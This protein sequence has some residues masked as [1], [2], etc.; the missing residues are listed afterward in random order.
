MRA[1]L[2][3]VV[4]SLVVAACDQ[5]KTSDAPAAP[6]LAAARA[7]SAWP[8]IGAADGATSPSALVANELIRSN[9]YVVF[10]ASGSMNESRCSGD[11]SKLAVAKDAL[12][13]FAKRLPANANL[14]LHV[15]DSQ[16]IRQVL[17]LGPLDR[18][19][20]ERSV[21][22]IRAGGGTPLA[23]SA[24]EAYAVLTAQARRQLGYG[25]YHLVIVTDGEATGA[26]PRGAVDRIVG[27]SP[28]LVNTIGFCIKDDHSLNQAGR[29]LY[30]AAD[31]PSALDQTL[32][33][34]LAEAPSFD[35]TRFEAAKK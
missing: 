5:N 19:A 35:V 33:D 13:R 11:R 4:V 22:A 30:K 14:G 3:G 32:A 16:G 26:D 31:N 17:P 20:L 18:E 27:E 10:D 23:E 21:D 28:V 1:L 7:A 8:F 6:H 15:F 12:L 29:T 24:L 34:V 2:V 25:E 9:Y